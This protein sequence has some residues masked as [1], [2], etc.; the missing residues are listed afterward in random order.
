ME[1]TASCQSLRCNDPRD[2]YIAAAE[3]E[4]AVAHA[5]AG[6]AVD[7][8]AYAS[9]PRRDKVMA[10]RLLSAGL[11]VAQHLLSRGCLVARELPKL[12]VHSVLDAFCRTHPRKVLDQEV[13]SGDN[14]PSKVV[15]V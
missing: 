7:G 2:L 10:A 13:R 14:G 3:G 6:V 8:R 5:A 1:M 9:L 11:H 15:G 12:Q 4:A